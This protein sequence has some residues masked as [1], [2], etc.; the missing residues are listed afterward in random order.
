MP[1]TRVSLLVGGEHRE[2]TP[3]EALEYALTRPPASKFPYTYEELKIIFSQQEDEKRGE[4]ISASALKSE[5]DRNLVL[6]RKEGYSAS[7]E[8]MFRAFHGTLLHGQLERAAPVGSVAEV[9]YWARID[10]EPVSCKPDLLDVRAGKLF[11][12]KT[13]EEV[14]VFDYPYK[15][16]ALQLQINRFIITH[17]ERVEDGDVTV[18]LTDENRGEWVPAEWSELVVV[19]VDPRRFK[20]ITVTKSVQVPKKSGEGTKSSRVP[21]IMEDDEVYD[22]IRTRREQISGGFEDYP[23]ALPPIPEGWEGQTGWLCG[24]CPVKARCFAYE[25]ERAAKEGVPESWLSQRSA[26]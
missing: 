14:P 12:Y 23:E 11:D 9:R 24:Y 21:Y 1:L 16:D 4:S 19:Y 6:T 17:A 3:D 5:C 8:S 18:L 7:I 20:P 15:G 22:F 26:Q 25:V 2:M 10:G 13:K